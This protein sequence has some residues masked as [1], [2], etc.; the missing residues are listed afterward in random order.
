MFRYAFEEMFIEHPHLDTIDSALKERTIST[1]VKSVFV[2]HAKPNS[3]VDK[4]E[5]PILMLHGAKF[6]SKTWDTTGMPRCQPP[7]QCI[8][9]SIGKNMYVKLCSIMFLDAL[10]CACL[11]L[12]T[13][14]F[15]FLSLERYDF[16]IV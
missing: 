12:A 2:M 10:F 3:R 5:L 7:P 13:D 1:R 6:S 8:A 15:Y 4:K 16:S 11:L 9:F 14:T